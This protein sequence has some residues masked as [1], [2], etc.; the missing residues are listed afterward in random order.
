MFQ[1]I[2]AI[3]FDCY[4]TLIDWE[5]GI[6]R[7]LRP[8]LVVH[9]KVLPDAEIVR[10]YAEFEAEE[11]REYKPYRDVLMNVVD[12]FAHHCGFE[13]EDRERER[14]PESIARWEPFPDTPKALA[15]LGSR[16]RL[17]ICS[18]IDD[19]LFQPTLAKLTA[20][21]ASFERVVTAQYCRSYKPDPRHFRVALA[22][23]GL[24][25][26]QVLHAAQSRYHDLAPAATLGMRTAWVNR[27]S[28]LDGR[29]M[30]PESA[31]GTTPAVSVKSLEE[32]AQVVED[33]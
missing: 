26:H 9:G 10:L 13:A 17:A 2:E 15:A 27:P 24:A 29:G 23:L 8:M 25:P 33:K 19:D 4:G 28:V 12:R 30:T 18:N 20:A 16:Y 5:K 1:G 3:T 21:G 31:S 22:L 32:L 11:E 6:L 7:A 14:L